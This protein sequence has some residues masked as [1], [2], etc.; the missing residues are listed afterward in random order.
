MF[1]ATADSPQTRDFF[2]QELVFTSNDY[3][4]VRR[5]LKEVAT[6]L[7]QGCSQGRLK[8]DLDLQAHFSGLPMKPRNCELREAGIEP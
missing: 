6:K 2:L 1:D 4:S 3:A 7:H 5:N 8:L